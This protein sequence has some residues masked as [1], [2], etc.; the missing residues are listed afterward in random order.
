MFRAC[1]PLLRSKETLQA[2]QEVATGY[3]QFLLEENE[4]GEWGEEEEEERVGG[5]MD[6]LSEEEELRLLE[7]MPAAKVRRSLRFSAHSL[8]P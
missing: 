5:G 2:L 7:E 8:A 6:R 4:D 1:F 3:A